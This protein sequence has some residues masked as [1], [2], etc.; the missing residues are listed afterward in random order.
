M[1]FTYGKQE[2]QISIFDNAENN[3]KY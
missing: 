1:N 3:R 2:R